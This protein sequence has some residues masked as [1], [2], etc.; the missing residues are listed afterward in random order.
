MN[1]IALMWFLACIVCSTITL[2]DLFSYTEENS[3]IE[4]N[5]SRVFNLVSSLGIVL[6]LFYEGV[7][8][9]NQG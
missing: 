4:L 2:M 3:K 9:F 1:F 5:P 6:F 7:V 8:A